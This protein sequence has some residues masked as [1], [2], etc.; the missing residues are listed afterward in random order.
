MTLNPGGGAILLHCAPNPAKMANVP[1]GNVAEL[2]SL[3]AETPPP[4]P[5]K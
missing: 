5:P 4:L 3:F 2:S 1:A